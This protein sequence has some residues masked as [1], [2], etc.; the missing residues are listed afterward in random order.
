M[1]TMKQFPAGNEPE[2]EKVFV[3]PQ[4]AKD[5]LGSNPRNRNIRP[6]VVAAYA[7]DM[8][9]G[10]WRM[11]G[12]PVKMDWNGDLLDG[13][14]RLRAIVET[15]LSVEL[16]VVQNLDPH[17]QVYMDAGMRRTASDALHL[18]GYKF[19]QALAAAA[20]TAKAWEEGR[21]ARGPNSHGVTRTTTPEILRF[22]E[23]HPDLEAAVAEADGTYRK[24]LLMRPVVVSTT[25]WR[26]RRIDAEAA[27][28]FY[29]ALANSATNGRGDPRAALLNR[30]GQARKQRE[31]MT[32]AV[33]IGI[34]CRAWNAWR[35]EEPLSYLVAHRNG[36]TILPEPH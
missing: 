8:R 17:T 3:T 21:L 14:H 23:E 31:Q 13:Q 26:F 32:V 27:H 16:F 5:W 24:M 34:T 15:G 7:R 18:Q 28:L 25:F 29:D 22:V 36:E 10:H 2:A 35:D 11:T 1:S 19:A 4:R 12:D 30:I 33:E 6:G 20:R 9:N